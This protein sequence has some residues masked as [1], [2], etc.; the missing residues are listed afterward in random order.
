MCTPNESLKLKIK[1]TAIALRGYN[2]GFN[3]KN[4]IFRTLR[5][6]TGVFLAYVLIHVTLRASGGDIW[7]ELLRAKKT[8]LIVAVLI[9]GAIIGMAIYR[10]NILLKVQKVYLGMWNL[11][12][13]SLIGVFSNLAIPGAVGGDLVKMAFLSQ[14]EK[15]KKPEAIMTIILDRSLGLL[16]LFLVASIVVLFYFQDLMHLDQKYRFIRIAA[17]TIGLGSLAGILGIFLIE[18]RH[19]LVKYTI[20]AKMVQYGETKL[21]KPV[22]FTITRLTNALELYRKH[23]RAIFVSILIS[24]LIHSCYAFNVFLVSRSI[25]ANEPGFSGFLLAVPVANAIAA[26]PVTPGGIGTRDATIAAYLNSMGT[27]P[28]MAGVI[29][30]IITLIILIWGLIGGIV[31][32][33]YRSGKP[34]TRDPRKLE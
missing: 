30:F 21:P 18:I 11:I 32:I 27:S 24:V 23:R 4:N 19:R 14:K 2:F 17:F 15:G 22:V 34:S 8:F 28:E 7:D 12:Q 5:F 33:F 9:H 13:L 29:P 3:N 6:I 31:F 16:G 25:G 20:V 10:W 26:I 1:P